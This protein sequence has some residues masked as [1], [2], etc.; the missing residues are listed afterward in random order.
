MIYVNIGNGFIL[1]YFKFC[2]FFIFSFFFPFFKKSEQKQEQKV[3]IHDP[4]HCFLK[5]NF[6]IEKRFLLTK[7][8]L[9]KEAQY[10]E[11]RSILHVGLLCDNCKGKFIFC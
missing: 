1:F 4:N 10:D 5:I 2:L 7:E 8:P 6:P 9:L 11:E 3:S